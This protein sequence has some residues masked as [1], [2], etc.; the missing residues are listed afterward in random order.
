MTFTDSIPP[1]HIRL[2]RYAELLAPCST[3]QHLTTALHEG[4]MRTLTS[5][6]P[7]FGRRH[8]L[9][10]LFR[11]SQARDNEDALLR[12]IADWV[13][14]AADMGVPNDDILGFVGDRFFAELTD[15]GWQ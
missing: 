10:F 1:E 2:E 6:D 7:A 5:Q 15:A 8:E 14:K 13:E 3:L 9:V 4:L 11:D 12:W